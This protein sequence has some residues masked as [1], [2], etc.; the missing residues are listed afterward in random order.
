[1]QDIE[2]DFDPF[3]EVVFQDFDFEILYQ[4]ELDG[5]EDSD[6]G[7]IMGVANLRFNDWFK[8]FKNAASEVHP[9]AVN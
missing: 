9:Y 6:A 1:L 5:L 3:E 7:A 4:M 8:P 2:D